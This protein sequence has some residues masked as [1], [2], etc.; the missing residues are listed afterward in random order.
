MKTY[1]FVVFRL[2]AHII[3]VMLA[4]SMTGCAANE[5]PLG[6]T[7]STET[8]V[9]TKPL[10]TSPT[11]NKPE[12]TAQTS[13]ETQ[14]A[15]IMT[16][17]ATS[18]HG[19]DWTEAMGE[20]S[21]VTES[22]QNT[23]M[24]PTT[25]PPTT[26]KLT[27]PPSTVPPETKPSH[28]H[29][30]Q[31]TDSV[32]A[33]CTEDGYTVYECSCGSSY[34]DDETHATGHRWAEWTV[35]KYPTTTSEG[36]RICT[37]GYCGFVGAVTIEKLPEDHVHEYTEIYHAATCQ[38]LSYYSYQCD[39]GDSYI[40][41]YFGELADHYMVTDEEVPATPETD[42]Y[43]RYRCGY[44]WDGCT[45]TKTLVLKYENQE[46][47]TAKL[48]EYGRQ[49]GKDTYG[50]TPVIGT[51]AGYYPGLSVSITSMEDGYHEVADCVD[52]TTDQLV[53]AGKP[54]VDVI[55]G[56]EYSFMLDVEVVHEGGNDYCVWVYYG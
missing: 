11:E 43:H 13:V 51:R 44:S 7:D 16:T 8:S 33:T 26:T 17:E 45:E 55:D 47:D 31:K 56:V 4:V 29:N 50:Y 12:S 23:T 41:E 52:S 24:P 18:A 40:G 2:V 20:D 27:E 39:C 10:D 9:A 54:I 22:T 37:C 28:S 38:H 14:S 15:E 53:A 6:S 35:T 49:Y 30:Y 3:A 5:L 48:E 19:E 1:K 46:I 36:E 34:F 21:P 25:E 32:A 42:G